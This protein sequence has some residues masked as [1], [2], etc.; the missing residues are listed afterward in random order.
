M[1][2][3]QPQVSK[4]DVWGPAVT[5]HEV[6]TT[7]RTPLLPSCP[8]LRENRSSVFRPFPEEN[9]GP[10]RAPLSRMPTPSHGSEPPPPPGLLRRRFPHAHKVPKDNSHR[11]TP[12]GVA[13]RP[14]DERARAP[15]DL[16]CDS[17]SP[18]V[19]NLRVWEGFQGLRLSAIPAPGLL[20]TPLS[21][22]PHTHTVAMAA[23]LRHGAARRWV[24]DPTGPADQRATDPGEAAT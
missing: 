14:A 1:A 12:A 7:K 10:I 23:W 5:A 16:R 2:Q 21:P 24:V 3:S 15:H 6:S 13:A 17:W 8:V 19:G 22:G 11:G 4:A 18:H 20:R 9:P